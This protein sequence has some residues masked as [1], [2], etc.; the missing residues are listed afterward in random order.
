M[1][2]EP[3]LH[4]DPLWEEKAELILGCQGEGRKGSQ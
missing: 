2:S 1:V 3:L 4:G